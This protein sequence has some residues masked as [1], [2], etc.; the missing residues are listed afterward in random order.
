MS[1]L[2]LSNW[3]NKQVQGEIP[4]FVFRVHELE[5]TD[6]KYKTNKEPIE[7]DWVGNWARVWAPWPLVEVEQVENPLCNGH[8]D[9]SLGDLEQWSVM[10]VI[11]LLRAWITEQGLFPLIMRMQYKSLYLTYKHLF[12]L[13]VYLYRTGNGGHHSLSSQQSSWVNF[14]LAYFIL[15]RKIGES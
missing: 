2:E 12:H 9:R 14:F 5:P 6:W 4:N 11:A 15:H 8:V 7:G 1:K 10:C 3:K 13:N